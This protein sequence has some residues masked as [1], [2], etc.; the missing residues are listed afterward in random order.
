MESVQS[1]IRTVKD[2]IRT[3]IVLNS[4]ISDSG[5][6]YGLQ[7]FLSKKFDDPQ[8][9]LVFQI[10]IGHALKA[11]KICS[12]SGLSLLK[13][14]VDTKI[15][16]VYDDDS[17]INRH[18]LLEKMKLVGLSEK[19]S[20][21]LESAFDLA[22][23]SGKITIK[24]SKNLNSFIEMN[25]GYVFNLRPLLK[26]SLEFYNP[27]ILCIDGFIE[28]VSEIH[29][30]LEW[31]S[32]SKKTLLTFARGYA[33]DV[34]HT[35]KVNND[36]GSFTL[37]PFVVPFDQDHAN[38]M[39]DISAVS[40]T[41]IVS[42]L[43]GDLISSIKTDSIQPVNAATV[44]KELTLRN[45]KSK[46]NVKIHLENLK[47]K[48]SERSDIEDLLVRRIR[49][50]SSKTVDI[51]LPDDIAFLSTSYKMDLVLRW[52]RDKAVLKINSTAVVDL[53]LKSL[54][55]LLGSVGCIVT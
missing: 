45:D 24:K 26:T 43:K 40:C 10:A 37:I 53:H 48:I 47:K 8:Q 30:L 17:L 9:N 15:V 1:T 19:Q 41:D 52:I 42:S 54:E 18:S 28:S 31:A 6:K 39:V 25:E 5:M 12:G 3:M 4:S 49:S 29:H 21:L 55:D 22:S 27:Y 16:D 38:T 34:L 33:D 2:Q 46:D 13:K 35:F 51:Y 7:T 36:R 23:F 32:D 44:G 11:E 50:L 20:S 14:F